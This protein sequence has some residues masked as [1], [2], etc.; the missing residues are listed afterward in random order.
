M[1][2][3]NNETSDGNKR[4]IYNRTGSSASVTTDIKKNQA[5]Q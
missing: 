4:W 2:Y 1:P 3:L 5:Q